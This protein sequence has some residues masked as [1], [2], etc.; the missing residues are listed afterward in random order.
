MLPCVLLCTIVFEFMQSRGF[1]VVE[2]HACTQTIVS[3]YSTSPEMH[4]LHVVVTGLL[5]GV[6]SMQHGRV[7][8]N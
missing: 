6:H 3:S 7:H 1:F 5:I 2:V 4:V 8:P